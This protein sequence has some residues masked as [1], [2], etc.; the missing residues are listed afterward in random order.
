MLLKNPEK[1]KYIHGE[2]VTLTAV[3]Y[4]WLAFP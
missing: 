1:D 4:D 2:E 3:P